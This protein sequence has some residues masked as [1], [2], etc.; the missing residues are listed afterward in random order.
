MSTN[1]EGKV[2]VITG[3][4]SGLGESTARHLAELGATVV[5]GARRKD[6]L[7]AIVKDITG[8]GGKALAVTVDVTK[9]EQV[10]A[11]IQAALKAYGKV[12]VLVNNAGIMPM[13]PL[14]ALK[15]DEWE[16]MIDINI[17]G[18]LYGIA[19]VLPVF[20][21]VRSGH[22][23]NLSSVAGIKVFAPGGSV[24]SGTKFALHAISEGLRMETRKNNIRVTIL[25][26]G[27]VDSEL[28]EGSSDAVASQNVKEFYKIAIPADSIARAIAY[29]IE[30]PSDVE[31]DEI[32]V[33]PTVQEF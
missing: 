5:L 3:A 11:L 17:K 26:P 24:Y 18:L 19:A 28:K 13:A 2:V 8:K 16:K 7:D 9:R 1:V 29:A 22:F 31:I 21:K 32:V 6:R 25:S 15:V 10:E 20:T 30:Q 27:A 33:R 23:I 4:S 14:A 12:D